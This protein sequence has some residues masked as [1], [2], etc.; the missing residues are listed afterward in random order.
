FSF[1]DGKRF[2]TV[3]YIWLIPILLQSNKEQQAEIEQLKVKISQ[4]ETIE[5]RLTALEA[6]LEE[7]EVGVNVPLKTEEK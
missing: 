5:S 4:Y 3:N 7:K 1:P 2:K 6:K